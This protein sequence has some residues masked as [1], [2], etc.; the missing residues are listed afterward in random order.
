MFAEDIPGSIE[1]GKLA[2]FVVIPV[3]CMIIPAED[4]W[5]IEP[6]FPS[7]MVEKLL[8]GAQFDI[9]SRRDLSCLRMD[10]GVSDLKKIRSAGSAKK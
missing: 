9:P 3:D 10:K 4:I 8:Y 1:V 7:R 5:K 6:V 2:D